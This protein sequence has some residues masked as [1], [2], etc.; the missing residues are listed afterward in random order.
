MEAR[1]LMSYGA[2]EDRLLAWEFE[3]PQLSTLLTAFLA[4]LLAIQLSALLSDLLLG[5]KTKNAS[6]ISDL[7]TTLLVKKSSPLAIASN[8][9]RRDW[10]TRLYYGRGIPK[11]ITV[12]RDP[13]RIKPAVAGKLLLLLAIAPLCNIAFV[14]LSLRTKTE[15]TFKDVGF[16]G[17]GLSIFRDGNTSAIT[18]N[19]N[20]CSALSVKT[21][22][23]DTS[24]V[25]FNLCSK[26]LFIPKSGNYYDATVSVT[27][28]KN[29][30]VI[31]GVAINNTQI[32]MWKGLT[33]YKNKTLYM[34]EE[35]LSLA[36]VESL[37]DSVIAVLGEECDL[38]NANEQ[39]EKFKDTAKY[40]VAEV[41]M[42]KRITCPQRSEPERKISNALVVAEKNIGVA[43]I[44]EIRI[45]E[46]QPE[47][48]PSTIPFSSTEEVPLIMR[49]RKRIRLNTALI[50]C[51]VVIILRLITT[52]FLNNDTDIGLERIIK[53]RLGLECCQSLLQKTEENVQ[54][55][56]KC[57][58]GKSC[59]YGLQREGMEVVREFES[60]I[61]GGESGM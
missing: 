1:D 14:V 30:T 27:L 8:L 45:T 42:A 17:I 57:R 6:T 29:H 54:Y 22:P 53:H 61:I 4:T 52:A 9:L 59:H 16:G 51:A 41:V 40:D 32:A 48:S 23:G 11:S 56:T 31:V 5:I 47:L 33:L 10:L 13:Q 3:N 2:P 18:R 21:K 15:L 58:I 19:I 37:I 38:P 26:W 55:D 20:S 28:S 36:E 44:E 49:T 46:Y 34:V 50:V 12:G 43:K 24:V 7:H 35:N 60:G 25:Q 39:S